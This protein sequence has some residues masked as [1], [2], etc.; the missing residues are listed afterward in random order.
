MRI[1]NRIVCLGMAAVM[2]WST[3]V[4]GEVINFTGPEGQTSGVYNTNTGAGPGSGQ[5]SPGGSQTLPGPSTG[6][7]AGATVQKPTIAAEGAVL[8]NANTG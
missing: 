2:M 8:L 7:T 3:T 6:N 1:W 5:T 4:Y